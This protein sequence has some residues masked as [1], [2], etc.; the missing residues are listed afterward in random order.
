M[1]VDPVGLWWF[2]PP[3]VFGGDF[4]VGGVGDCGGYFGCWLWFYF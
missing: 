1:V 3:Q 4:V 2:P